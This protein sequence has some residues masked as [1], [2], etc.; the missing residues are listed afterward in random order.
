MADYTIVYIR[1]SNEDA[2]YNITKL[3]DKEFVKAYVACAKA[4]QKVY[5]KQGMKTVDE[6]SKEL[7]RSRR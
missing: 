1:M 6:Y 4:A 2:Q 7:S 5:E 3:T